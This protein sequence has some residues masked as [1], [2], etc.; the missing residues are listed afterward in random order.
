MHI[1][2]YKLFLL[3]III[4]S[5]C[6]RFYRLPDRTWWTGDVARDLLVGYHIAK[7]NE[8]PIVGHVT[9]NLPSGEFYYPPYYYYLI[10]LV[11]KINSNPMFVIGVFVFMSS[12][13][14][15][16]IYTVASKLFSKKTGLLSAF[17][18]TISAY[19]I[20]SGTSLW[21][22]FVVV[23]VFYLG[24]AIYLTAEENIVVKIIGLLIISV[25][26]T[27][28]YSAFLMLFFVL[29]YQCISDKRRTVNLFIISIVLIYV[30]VLF[31]PLL[32]FFGLPTLIQKFSINPQ[33]ALIVNM[34]H[35][36]NILKEIGNEFFLEDIRL[37]IVYVFCFVIL[38]TFWVL[39]KRKDKNC[40]YLLST[41]SFFVVIVILKPGQ[42]LAGYNSILIF[43]I[44]I[45]ISSEL[46]ISLWCNRGSKVR[47]IY[48]VF[49]VL[50][51]LCL[52]GNFLPYRRLIYE[53]SKSER[54]VDR[55][56]RESEQSNISNNDFLIYGSVYSGF[57]WE[58]PTFWYFMETKHNNKVVQKIDQNENL[59]PIRSPNYIYLVCKDYSKEDIIGYCLKYLTKEYN[60][61]LVD[62][63]NSSSENLRI[64]LFKKN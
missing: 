7:F 37:F 54:V 44:I 31:R 61:H 26:S 6:L 2:K 17:Y 16:F 12:L 62:E 52:V 39:Q 55:I 34:P 30:C 58:S 11:T 50:I 41:A 40:Y 42:S 43:P 19:G 33:Q 48:L 27:I 15:L 14:P 60:Y 10:G 59:E 63:R 64:F 1:D 45:V 28:H 36:I 4:I 57:L 53:F 21:S 38:L 32:Y 49:A 22:A 8:F 24:L 56:Y 51:G 5:V 47:Y 20:Y 18:Y 25:S 13:T 35:I 29:L 23:P 9:N 46:I 3:F